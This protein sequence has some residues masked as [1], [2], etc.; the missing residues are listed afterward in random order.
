MNNTYYVLLSAVILGT[1]AGISPGP[2]LALVITETIK[3]GKKEGIKLA[4]VPFITDLPI[5][6]I[7]IL[8]LSTI[9]QSDTILG[10]ISLSGCIF[11]IYLAWGSLF[12]KKEA[13]PIAVNPQSFRKGIIT[14]FLSPHPYLFWIFVGGN[15]VVDAYQQSPIAAAAFLLLFYICLTGSKMLVALL[16]E[17]FRNIMSTRAYVYTI[18]VLGVVLL[19]L[20]LQLLKEGVN[21]IF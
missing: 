9:S 11:L 18:R 6:L 14:N 10:I 5:I 19:L 3:Y 8:F 1:T 7:S 20:A 13:A 4:L 17:K 12:Y 21:F 15:Y 2:L 16:T